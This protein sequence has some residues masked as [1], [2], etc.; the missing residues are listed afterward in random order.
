[1]PLHLPRRP[2]LIAR[3][4]GL[5]LALL[6]GTLPLAACSDESRLV[7]RTSSGDHR[8]T[9]EVVDT[10][11]KRAEGLMFRQE[12]APDAGM[13]FD[14]KEMR[15]VSFWMRNTFIPLDMIFISPDGTV[16]NVHVNA[17][18]HDPTGIPSGVPVQFVLEIPG[19]RSVEIGLEPG[20]KVEH[21]RM[22]AAQ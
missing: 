14:F 16:E 5:L 15:E 19:G 6:V 9:V 8:F 11:Q 1:M 13:L 22:K 3:A 7:I 2:D 17:R 18:P 10:P 20:D 4:L 21:P 12:L